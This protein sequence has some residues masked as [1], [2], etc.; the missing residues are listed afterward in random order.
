ML[1]K[2]CKKLNNGI[3]WVPKVL[4]QSNTI[5]EKSLAI[6]E[7]GRPHNCEK[8]IFNELRVNRSPLRYCYFI[9]LPFK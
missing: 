6:L 5:A 8:E 1:E 7:S 3:E 9:L 2:Q 4:E